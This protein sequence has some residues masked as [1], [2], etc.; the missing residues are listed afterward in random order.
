MTRKRIGMENPG[1]RKSVDHHTGRGGGAR[2]AGPGRRGQGAKAVWRDL[3]WVI[4]C[5]LASLGG[6]KTVQITIGTE[7]L[8]LGCRLSFVIHSFCEGGGKQKPKNTSS[9]CLM[10]NVLTREA[11]SPL[12]QTL[13]AI[14]FGTFYPEMLQ[15]TDHLSETMATGVGSNSHIEQGG[16][17]I[18]TKLSV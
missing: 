13:I 2:E 7:C 9:R 3:I 5:R 6:Q 10:K 17:G 11:A 4:D 18:R 16:P 14:V 12:K 8:R 1:L 15:C